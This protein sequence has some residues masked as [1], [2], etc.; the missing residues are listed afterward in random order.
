MAD[1]DVSLLPK[2]GFGDTLWGK[3]MNWVLSVGRYIVIFTELIVIGAFI[4]RFWLDRKNSDLSEEIR[5]QE[6]ILT[7][8]SGF[9]EEFRLF[10]LRLKTIA[11][12]AGT[13]RDVSFPLELIAEVLP[14]GTHLSRYGFSGKGKKEISITISFFSESSLANFVDALLEKEEVISVKIGTI[15]RKQGESGMRI[16]FIISFKDPD[17]STAAK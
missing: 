14:K 11:K 16:Q 8:T 15:E 1:R 12:V 17:E 13:S 6:A 7:S 3:L 9:E 4:S 2:Q 5:Q 10:Q